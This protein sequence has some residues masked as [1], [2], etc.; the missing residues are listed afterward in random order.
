MTPADT[1][2]AVEKI[3]DVAN[4]MGGD[5]PDDVVDQL[6]TR[7]MDAKRATGVKGLPGTIFTAREI[8]QII[9]VGYQ[10]LE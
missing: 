2:A 7:L 4:I 9:V 6:V 1:I 8:V 3:R 10:E 5:A